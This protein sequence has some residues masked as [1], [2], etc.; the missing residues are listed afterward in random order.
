MI[1]DSQILIDCSS[2]RV[3]WKSLVAF[4]SL[5]PTGIG[6]DQAC[7]DCEARVESLSIS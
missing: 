2:R 5:L 3:R 4:D 1:E 7:I 6:R